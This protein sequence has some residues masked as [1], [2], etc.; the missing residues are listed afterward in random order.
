MALTCIKTVRG[1][2]R[3][4]ALAL[5][6]A[7]PL[8]ALPAGTDADVLAARDA[9][10]RANWKVVDAA[11]ARVAGHP[12]EAYVTYWLLAGTIDRADAAQVREFLR[13]H[14]GTPLGESLRREWV[15]A[16]AAAG[17]WETFRA[18]APGVVSDDLEI[19]CYG[20]TDRLARGEAEAA[21]EG[22]ALFNAAR[23]TPAACDPVFARL[24]ADGRLKEDEIW[25]RVRRLLAASQLREARKANALLPARI[26]LDEKTLERVAA[27]PARHLLRD[28]S[29][30]V[31]RGAKELT[32][33]AVER[34]ARTRAEEAADRLAPMKGRLGAEATSFAWGQVAFQAAM[35]HEPRALD[36]YQMAADAPLTEAQAAW[37]AR[38]ALRAGNWKT[39]LAAIQAL[40]PE[41]AREPAW[42]YWRARAWKQLGEAEVA[43]ELLKGLAGEFN[44]YGLLAAEELGRPS[45]V[46]GMERR[47]PRRR[48]ARSC[49]GASRHRTRPRALPHRP[50]QRGAA[51][52]DLVA[53]RHGRPQPP[54]RGRGRAPGERSRPR[55]SPPPTARC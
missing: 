14:D 54:R 21:G 23:E 24:V 42:R 40:P 11:R 1:A 26:A 30:L 8:V 5:A 18:E 15:K 36:Y 39:V 52:M 9:A 28:K 7:S 43:N 49:T 12:L 3:V 44:F 51:R 45:A 48:R 34:L 47:A 27:D 13:R 55:R 31:S 19:A 53:A 32:I 4:L 41:E 10:L 46:P 50:R 38:A 2:T 29:A 16:L 37:K 35:N 25:A 6:A 33:F 20:L 22:R 17:D